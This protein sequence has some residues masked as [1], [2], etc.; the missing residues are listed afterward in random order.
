LVM[1]TLHTVTHPQIFLNYFTKI[2]VSSD[3]RLLL[4]L[5]GDKLNIAVTE[6]VY[7]PI[8]SNHW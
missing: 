7:V 5:Y 2:Y 8:Q 6:E 3:S 1:S 4:V